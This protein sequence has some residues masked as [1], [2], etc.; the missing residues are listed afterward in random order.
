MSSLSGIPVSSQFF[1]KDRVYNWP[2]PVHGGTTFIRYFVKENS[3]VRITIFDI[4]GDLVT[5]LSAS[6]IGGVDNEVPWDTG[7]VQS[8]IYFARI[9]ATGPGGSGVAIIKIAVV[10]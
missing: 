5:E 7:G 1:P 4:A 10:K 6:G 2:N 9:E 3:G 8:G